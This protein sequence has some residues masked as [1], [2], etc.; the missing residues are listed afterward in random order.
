MIFWSALFNPDKRFEPD[1]SKSPEWNS[2]AYLAEALAHCGE[3]HTPRN[4]G[5]RAGQPQEIRRRDDGGLARLQHLLGQGHRRRRLARR[6]PDLLSFDSATRRA[7]APPRGRW[8][9]RS[10]TASA[11]SR[12]RT[13]AR[14]S[15]I[16][17]ACRRRPRPTCRRRMR[18]SRPPRT[19]T[20]S[21]RMR[22]ARWCSPGACA[23]CHGWTGESPLS[24]MATLTGAWAVNDPAATNVAQIVIS[25]TKRHTPD[26]RALDAGVRQ[27]LF[28]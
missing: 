28:R 18:R 4:L 22:A 11:S 26:G 5:V 24:P 13:S 1:T 14:S 16:C 3:C 20:A 19:R 25:G 12:P 10:T 21:R 23:S 17:A 9:K 8:A 2:G 15:P 7:T 6:R 27:R